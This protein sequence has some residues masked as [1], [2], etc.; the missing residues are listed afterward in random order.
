MDINCMPVTY[1]FFNFFLL[2]ITS[3]KDK[4]NTINIFYNKLNKRGVSDSIV[5]SYITTHSHSNWT[6]H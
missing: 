4:Q 1:N 6:G 2:S 5:I 3:L